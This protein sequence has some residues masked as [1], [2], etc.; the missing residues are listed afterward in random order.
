MS[1]RR[2]PGR[3]LPLRHRP[4]VRHH[5]IPWPRS[6]WSS[7]PRV[8]DPYPTPKRAPGQA[9]PPR[10]GTSVFSGAEPSSVGIA[11]MVSPTVQQPRH[12][13]H[14]ARRRPLG[15][16]MARRVT[17]QDLLRPDVSG[18]PSTQATPAT[19][20]RF[21]R[22]NGEMACAGRRVRGHRVPH[23]FHRRGWFNPS[24]LDER[25]RPAH[26]LSVGAVLTLAAV[27]LLPELPGRP[28]PALTTRCRLALHDIPFSGV[29][30]A[31]SASFKCSSLQT[32]S[33]RRQ[34][35]SDRC[36]ASIWPE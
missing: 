5:R 19:D 7:R 1:Q 25:L 30:L 16:V 29:V 6:P 33:R 13:Q 21:C 18:Q 9:S 34:L 32:T 3:S 12:P 2:W 26:L 11:A 15:P 4:R 22:F 23:I 27:W 31:P 36:R 24:N 10:S 17:G 8:G 35:A 20:S 14:R 28:G